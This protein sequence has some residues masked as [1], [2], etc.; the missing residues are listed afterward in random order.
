MPFIDCI[1]LK[2]FFHLQES[3]GK[4]ERFRK[5]LWGDP[6]PP[7]FAGNKRPTGLPRTAARGREIQ[8]TLPNDPANTPPYFV[9]CFD[10]DENTAFYS[11]YKVT[12]EQ[13]AKLGTY[14]REDINADNWRTPGI[15]CESFR[16]S[17]SLS[18][19]NKQTPIH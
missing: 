8:Q 11:A 4:W 7:F 19:A 2:C 9:S 3:P 6:V 13:A 12:P 18:I 17:L 1:F 5:L 15:S 10:P 14:K 16:I